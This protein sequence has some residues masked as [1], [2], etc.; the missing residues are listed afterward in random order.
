MAQPGGPAGAGGGLDM[1]SAEERIVEAV[2]PIVAVCEPDFY[3]PESG[4]EVEEEY[5]TYAVS[6]EPMAFGDNAPRCVRAIVTLHWY[7]P[8]GVRPNAKRLALCRAL[9]AA[10][11][12]YPVVQNAT[13]SVGQHWVFECEGLEEA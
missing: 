6:A 11:F 2:T 10:G 3:I 13:D 1:K 5:C 12:T 9:R 8:L 4:E 7:L